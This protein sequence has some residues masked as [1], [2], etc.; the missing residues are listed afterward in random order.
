MKKSL[1]YAGFIVALNLLSACAV[2]PDYRK[3]DPVLPDRWTPARDPS[4]GLKKAD[5]GALSTWWESF[6]DP[7]LTRLIEEGKNQNL[8]FRIA[9]SRIDQARSEQNANRASLFPRI[10][11][12]ANGATMSNLFPLNLPNGK[13]LNYFLTGFDA[14][15]EIDLFGRLRRK[16]E[17]ATA[18]TAA[19]AEETREAFVVLSAE[20]GRQYMSYRALQLQAHW[21]EANLKL[22][23][24]TVALAEERVRNGL[25]S[26]DEVAGARA[27]FESTASEIR[28][29]ESQ[30]IT[31]RHEIEE[32]IG[33]K[34][35]AL[36]VRLGEVRNIPSADERRLLTQPADS[37]R[38]R[39]DI[40]SAE[41]ELESATATQGAAIA[42]LF[43][44]ISVG[45]FLGLRNS[46]LENLFR[47]SA[48]AWATG[49]SISQPIF[50]F[51][52]I[53]AG[54]DLAE[55]RQREAYLNYEKTVLA[56]LHETEEALT[57]FLKESKRMN[58]LQHSLEHLTQSNRMAEIRYQNG[59]A[60][61]QAWLTTQLDLNNERIRLIQSQSA[62][63]I[64]LIAVFKALGGAGQIP[65]EIKEEP[66]RPWG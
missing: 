46:D 45:A 50:N 61:R 36:K 7:E 54:I 58:H 49:A 25:A 39:P 15:W 20:I 2:G 13:G 55:A 52:Q 51:G 63:A 41:F 8:D 47:S 4:E 17:A 6:K 33:R 35:D 30:L 12:T 42:E 56:A 10:G 40:R 65:I 37:L 9:L 34:P 16:L 22:R 48:F 57:A 1:S 59:L 18:Q 24:E 60:T 31:T 23:G 28:S 3:P 19:S 66:L 29:V 11:A 21:L 44:K 62:L 32:L 27:Q 14:I 64:Q 26:Q 5:E 38:L 43:P 53:R